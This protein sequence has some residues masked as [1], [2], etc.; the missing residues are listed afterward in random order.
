MRNSQLT[1]FIWFMQKTNLV[2]AEI[3]SLMS[4]DE[5]RHAGYI[6]ILPHYYHVHTHTNSQ[7]IKLTSFVELVGKLYDMLDYF[8]DKQI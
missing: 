4:R 2:V 1:S 3:F 7:V 6:H 8:V 5:A